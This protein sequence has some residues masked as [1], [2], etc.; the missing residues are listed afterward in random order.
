MLSQKAFLFD[1]DGV[2]INTE[3]QYVIF[4]REIAVKYNLGIPNFEYIIK[5]NTTQNIL[6]NYFSHLSLSEQQQIENSLQEFNLKMIIE[7]I[8]GALEFIREL[9]RNK[10]KIGLVTSSDDRKLEYVFSK[11]PLFSSFDTLISA[12]RVNEGKPDPMCYL[13]A[14]QDLKIA[15]VDCFVFEDSYNGLEAGNNAGMSVI[16]LSTTN[17][18]ENIRK[19]CVKVIP[20]FQNIIIEEFDTLGKLK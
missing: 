18:E 20:D 19:Y 14:A 8:P 15:P 11:I 4:W 12:D 2:L 3:P 5:G 13:M 10:I 17:T 7:P 6:K 9:K 1:L 16:G